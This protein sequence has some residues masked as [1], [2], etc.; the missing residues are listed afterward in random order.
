ME[1][2]E[3]T[4]QN[5]TTPVPEQPQESPPETPDVQPETQETPPPPPTPEPSGASG[6]R[7]SDERLW[8]MLCH[9]SALSMYIGVPFGNIIGPLVVWLIKKEE[10]PFVDSQGKESL[11][12]QIIVT[13]ALIICIPLAFFCIGLILIPIIL[14]ASLILVIIASVKANGGEEYKYPWNIRF[15]K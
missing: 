1:H 13:I 7:S 11:N 6:E 2:E 15:I 10:Y 8:G 9:L 12:F 3:Q 4:N 14:I 5:E